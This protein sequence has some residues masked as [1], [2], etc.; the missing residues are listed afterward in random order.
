MLSRRVRG[1]VVYR[2]GRAVLSKDKAWSL[3]CPLGREQ[4]LRYSQTQKEA[5]Y[6]RQYQ[7]SKLRQTLAGRGWTGETRA[8]LDAQATAFLVDQCGTPGAVPSS[9]SLCL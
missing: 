7:A 5:V 3:S 2:I 1:V 4:Q 9:S 8:S 6:P